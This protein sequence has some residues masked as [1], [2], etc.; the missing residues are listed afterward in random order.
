MSVCPID[1]TQEENVY[2]IIEQLDISSLTTDGLKSTENTSAYVAPTATGTSTN[3]NSSYT[4]YS[5]N[6][7]G[8]YTTRFSLNKNLTKIKLMG[9]LETNNT[10][11]TAIDYSGSSVT[12]SCLRGTQQIP[13]TFSNSVFSADVEVF[14][15]VDYKI[16]CKFTDSSSNV[17]AADYTQYQYNEVSMMIPGNTQSS[18]VNTGSFLLT[19]KNGQYCNPNDNACWTAQT[20]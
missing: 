4:V 3:I 15:G 11:G 20:L 7:N 13:T 14:K 2:V 16:K 6:N 10:Q 17:N 5:T 8:S 18:E 1:L 12:V 9:H 19:T